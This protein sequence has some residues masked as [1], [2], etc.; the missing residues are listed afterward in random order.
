MHGVFE[1]RDIFLWDTD[2][3][4]D[5]VLSWWNFLDLNNLLLLGFTC[6]ATFLGV[7]SFWLLWLWSFN[8]WGFWLN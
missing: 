8:L 1:K 4:Q 7:I 6:F 5:F 2:L 3:Q